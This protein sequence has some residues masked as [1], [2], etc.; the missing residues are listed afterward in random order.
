MYVLSPVSANSMKQLDV[1]EAG[2]MSEG[3]PSERRGSV[4]S[5]Q[6]YDCVVEPAPP[7]TVKYGDR[8]RLWAK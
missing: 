4:Q 2:A 8:L 1:S 3:T 7:S 6:G 5:I